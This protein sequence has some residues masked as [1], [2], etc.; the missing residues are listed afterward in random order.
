MPR[1]SKRYTE[2]EGRL[3][4][5]RRNLLDF[6]PPPPQSKT[7]YTPQ[8]LDLTRSYVLLAHAEIEAFCEDLAGAK[9]RSA[10]NTFDARGKVTPSLRRILS[11][12]ICKERKSWSEV[13]K[14]SVPTVRIAWQSHLSTIES[15]NGVKRQNLEKLF[16][17]VGIVE[18]HLDATWLAEMDSFGSN[19]GNWAHNSIKVLNV[20][21]PASEVAT[22]AKLLQGLLDLDRKMSKI[23]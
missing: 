15:N 18:P 5:L 6:L 2:L 22:V 14:P 10:R 12:Y 21:D 23:K 17:P 16:Y 9:A 13:L 20:P 4:D 1:G 3:A 8:E 11:Y 7:S 19:R